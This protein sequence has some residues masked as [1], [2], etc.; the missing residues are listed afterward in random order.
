MKPVD[1]AGSETQF[2]KRYLSQGERHLC[3]TGGKWATGNYSG[4]RVSQG[5]SLKPASVQPHFLLAV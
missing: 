1:M 5:L 2:K 4:L 3:I